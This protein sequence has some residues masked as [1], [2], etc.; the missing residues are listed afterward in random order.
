MNL[1]I[2][3]L[4]LNQLL[5]IGSTTSNPACTGQ[6][7]NGEGVNSSNHL[8]DIADDGDEEEGEEEEDDEPD[9]QRRSTEITNTNGV[10]ATIAGRAT[11]D[12]SFQTALVEFLLVS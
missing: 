10:A 4:D 3:S 6:L 12:N 1:K 9:E 7:D 5:G 2:Q 8:M 11:A